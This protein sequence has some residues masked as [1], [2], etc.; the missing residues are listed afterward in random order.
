MIPFAI[1]WPTALAA[2]FLQELNDHYCENVNL[3]L[4][5]GTDVICVD[6]IEDSQRVKLA[7]VPGQRLPSFYTVSGKAILAFLSE[8]HVK[9]VLER[10]M[11]RYT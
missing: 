4:L 10:G 9:H 2:P 6:V 1:E 5:D 3:A 7:A 8:N 11:L